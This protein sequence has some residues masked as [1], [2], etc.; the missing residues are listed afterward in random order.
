MSAA[1]SRPRRGD[2]FLLDF[3]PATGHEMTGLHPCVVVQ[4]DLGNQHTSLT[5]VAAITGNLRVAS[6]PVGVLVQAG[7]GGLARDSVIHC[8]HIYSVDQTR[9]RTRIGQ[10]PASVLTQVDQALAASLALP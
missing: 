5:I 9:L 1:P 10:L 8:G 4:N 6:L 7:V 3:A 2:I